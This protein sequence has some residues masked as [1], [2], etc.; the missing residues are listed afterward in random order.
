[1]G[2]KQKIFFFFRKK[3]F[4]MADSKKAYF[5]AQYFFM[6]IYYNT[7]IFWF[8]LKALMG[9][10][11]TEI[12]ITY[13]KILVALYGVWIFSNVLYQTAFFLPKH[14]CTTF[15]CGPVEDYGF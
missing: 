2:M 14:C 5:P 8:Q 1:M 7:N 4:K 6:K 15:E 3:K 9:R 13:S 10:L 12:L 11:E